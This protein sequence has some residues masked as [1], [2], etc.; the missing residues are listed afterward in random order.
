[1]P[2][3]NGAFSY[4]DGTLCVESVPVKQLVSQFGTPLYVYSQRYLTQR[5]LQYKAALASRNHLVCYAVKANSNLSILKLLG[6][7]GA[8]FDIVSGGELARVIAAGVNPDR[9]VFSGVGKSRTEITQALNAG[10]GCFNIESVDE[11]E[12]IEAIA[13]Q[14]GKIAPIACRVNPNV[15]PKTH[16]YIS[17]G[18]EK[19]KFGLTFDAAFDIYQRA[20]QSPACRVEGISCHIGSQLIDYSPVLE[21]LDKVILMVDRLEETGITLNHID[22][23][24]GLG[25]DYQDEVAPEISAFC[26][27]LLDRL[28]G[29]SQALWLEPGR[30][31]VGNAGILVTT[32]EY[33]KK[34]PKK[35]FIV[36]DAAMNDLMRPALYDA[37]H[38]IHPVMRTSETPVVCDV[39]G[40][41][42]ETGDFFARDRKLAAKADDLLAIFSAGA[43]G[44]TMSSNYNSRPRA[45]EVLIEGETVK[46]IRARE[47]IE[48]LY[49]PEL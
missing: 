25:I 49:A 11:F 35:T 47:T 21:A 34:T 22:I 1:M 33:V 24:G 26:D 6:Q 37:W 17:T 9:V 10:I 23:G 27:A 45:A 18:L 43:Y 39:V 40:P 20:A 32:V 4:C 30:S 19:N 46:L 41:I 16:P 15:D 44:A 12:R 28:N 13:M 29:R 8:G 5:F 48:M 38:D 36:V 2:Q 3:L 42:C 31:I 14:L 7:L